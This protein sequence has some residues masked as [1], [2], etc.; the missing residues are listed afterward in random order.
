MGCLSYSTKVVPLG[1]LLHGHLI[2]EGD[3]T[4]PV[5]PQDQLLSFSLFL[6]PLLHQ[7]LHPG[8]LSAAVPWVPWRLMIIMTDASNSG[9]WHQLSSGHYQDK[10]HLQQK[11]HV[12]VQEVM[13]PPTSFS[14]CCPCRT[15]QCATALTNV[16]LLRCLLGDVLVRDCDGNLQ[17]LVSLSN[18]SSSSNSPY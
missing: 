8:L 11:L 17:T 14:E 10:G 13:G 9:C 2:F 18:S 6:L 15:S 16:Y 5:T 1:R 12:N 4:Y 7:W 3:F